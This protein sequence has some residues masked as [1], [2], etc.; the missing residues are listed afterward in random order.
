MEFEKV[1]KYNVEFFAERDSEEGNNEISGVAIEETTSLN[2]VR[3]PA[4]VLQRA[5]ESLKG[6]PLLKDHNNSVDSI[7]GRVTEALFDENSKAVR[8]KAHIMDS[9][10]AEKVKQG[11]IKH[12]SVG[13]HFTGVKSER[14]EGGA[15]VFVPTDIRFLELSLVAVPGIHNAMIDTAIAEFVQENT[16]VLEKLEKE[17]EEHELLRVEK[18]LLETKLLSLEK[19]RRK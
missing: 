9:K 18:L 13:S 7:V 8:F 19:Q 6:V 4:E 10:I 3:Y 2:K 17:T 12:V 11:L 14:A 5:A 1:L 15:R 16:Y